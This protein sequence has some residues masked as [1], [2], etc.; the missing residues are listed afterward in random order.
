MNDAGTVA[1][2]LVLAWLVLT[3]V[4][5]LI[6]RRRWAWQTLLPNWRLYAP[7]GPPTDVALLARSDQ[8]TTWRRLDGWANG[9][10]RSDTKPGVR[11]TKVETDLLIDILDNVGPGWDP[12][13]CGAHEL[14]SELTER[15]LAVDGSTQFRIIFES[16][17]HSSIEYT[18]PWRQS[19]PASSEP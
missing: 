18:S 13:V 5:Q 9:S 11:L 7:T 17:D 6:V 16:A 10:G 15:S 19:G 2:V 3:V 1:V 14:V 8:S 4:A 12:T